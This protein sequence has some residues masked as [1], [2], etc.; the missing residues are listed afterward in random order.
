MD[1]IHF[2]RQLSMKIG[3]YAFKLCQLCFAEQSVTVLLKR[4]FPV[5]SRGFWVE[6]ESA[7]SDS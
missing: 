1:Q 5:E 7:E 4:N 2:V 3:L 6:S